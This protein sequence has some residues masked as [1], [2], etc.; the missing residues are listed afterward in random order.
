MTINPDSTLVL[1]V[2]GAI[3]VLILPAAI[4]ARR[5]FAARVAEDAAPDLDPARAGVTDPA[6]AGE[7]DDLPAA[8]A[9][10][11][12]AHLREAISYW[13]AEAERERVRANFYYAMVA[14]D[15]RR[16]GQGG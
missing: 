5:R 2:L 9:G 11:N 16:G 14:G 1:F 13:R 12:L 6:V 4:A 3:F 8:C 15:N 7:P 10:C